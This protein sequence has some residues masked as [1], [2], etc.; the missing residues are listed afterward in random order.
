[1][2]VKYGGHFGLAIFGRFPGGYSKALG[3]SP[4]LLVSGRRNRGVE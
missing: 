3:A 1:M 2:S 4:P